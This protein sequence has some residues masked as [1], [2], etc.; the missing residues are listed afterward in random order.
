MHMID[1]I[2]VADTFVTGLGAVKVLQGGNVRFTCY[3]EHEAEDGS[4]YRVVVS[5]TIMSR[6][7]IAPA[8]LMV[9]RETGI[10]IGLAI[11]DA[12]QRFAACM[13]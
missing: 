1:P 12:A 11:R 3:V 8:I 9:L 10:D 5:K 7:F 4:V 13:N 2:G 6:E